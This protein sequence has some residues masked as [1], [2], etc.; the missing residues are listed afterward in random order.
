MN[1]A[2]VLSSVRIGGQERVA[3]DLAS[4]Q[5]EAG[6]AVVVVS[7]APPPDGPLAESFRARGVDVER[8]A[9][10]PGV[11]PTLTLRLAALFR[12]RKI[13]VV[14]THNR[15]PLIYGAAAGKLAGAVVVH[16][17]HGPGRGTAAEQ[18]LRR[19]AGLLL[20]AYV[21]VSPE[22]AE[23]AGELGDCAPS[24]LAVIENG[25]DLHRFRPDEDARRA[26]RAM[27]G[28]P[29]DAWL[30]G[31]VG[32]L[33]PEKDYPL[34]VRALAPELGP[35]SRLLIVGDG[36]EDGA[37]RAEVASRQVQS[38]VHLPGSTNDTAPFLAAMDAF[39]LSSRMEGLPLVA[40]EA[41]ATGVPV[42]APAVGGLPGLI[43]NGVTGFLFPAGNEGALRERLAALRTDPGLA[44]SVGASGQTHVRERHAREVMVKR[45]LELY[46]QKGARA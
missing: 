30:V 24:K 20:D 41:M 8:V 7:L 12:R 33:A 19:G 42:V 26:T 11:D 28:I 36:S 35:G 44:R 18:W 43:R 34:L 45:Y 29:A 31:S 10:R 13:A 39:A 16:T 40:L 46:A 17:R 15:M 4:G 21:A 22:L 9:K 6:H 32:R 37:I 5:R 27:L 25:I 1:I 23:L 2:H 14:H 38:F 3:L